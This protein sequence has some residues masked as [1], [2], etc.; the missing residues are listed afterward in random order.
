LHIKANFEEKKRDG[1]D[2]LPK[3]RPMIGRTRS[4]EGGHRTLTEP[5]P[6][7]ALAQF[8]FDRDAHKMKCSTERAEARFKKS[9]TN[10]AFTITA[11]ILV[12]KA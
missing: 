8:H 4:K 12:P 2:D 10:G 5:N 11:I 6:S 9:R 3:K 7:A 1:E